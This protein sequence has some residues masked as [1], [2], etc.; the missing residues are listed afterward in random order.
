MENRTD[1]DCCIKY[2][3]EWDDNT[4]KLI[5]ENEDLKRQVFLLVKR[6]ELSKNSEFRAKQES[7]QLHKIVETLQNTV[8][9]QLKILDDNE[10]K[11]HEIF[12]LK[13]E[14]NA[15]E[16]KYQ[17]QENEMKAQMEA[18][19][20]LN[21]R[22]L[23]LL[24]GDFEERFSRLRIN[25]QSSL[26]EKEKTIQELKTKISALMTEK[27]NEVMKTRLEYE[28]KLQKVH[29]K[30][31][32]VVEPQVQSANSSTIRNDILRRKLQ[33]VQAEAQQE[34]DTLKK[35][36]CELEKALEKQNSQKKRKLSF[37]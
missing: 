1:I 37:H 6:G 32:S 34:I 33:H 2:V 29:S 30:Q 7:D 11:K 5:K 25:M 36:V 18:L 3:Q 31:V 23:Q 4:E 19:T 16:K 26:D 21:K 14:V 24:K 8:D 12:K 28:A 9:S 20:E 10:K 22:E 17:Q 35:R 13:E 27:Q 15:W